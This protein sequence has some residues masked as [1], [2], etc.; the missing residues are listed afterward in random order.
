MLLTPLLCAQD[1]TNNPAM[2][3]EMFPI[4][5]GLDLLILAIKCRLNERPAVLTLYVYEQACH[6]SSTDSLLPLNLKSLERAYHVVSAC[7][8]GSAFGVNLPH[9]PT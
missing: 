3:H 6:Y 9:P 5:L 7:L 1:M 2:P 8:S 4:N